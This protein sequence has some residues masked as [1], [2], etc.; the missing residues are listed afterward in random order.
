MSTSPENLK[1]VHSEDNE[2]TLESHEYID[3]TT[4]EINYTSVKPSSTRKTYNDLSQN[5]KETAKILNEVDEFWG[6]R[7]LVT[8]PTGENKAFPTTLVTVIT[9]SVLAIGVGI[10]LI[11]KYVLK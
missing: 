8:K 1:Y 3:D 9:S 10:L 2:I 11:K 4:Q 7:V 6:E 5:E